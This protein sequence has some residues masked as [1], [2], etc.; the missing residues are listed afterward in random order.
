M[1]FDVIYTNVT[2]YNYL[3]ITIVDFNL[4]CHENYIKNSSRL[5]VTIYRHVLI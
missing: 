2:Y 4:I 3:V 5:T 1:T